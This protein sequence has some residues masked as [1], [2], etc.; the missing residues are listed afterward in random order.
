V[1]TDVYSLQRYEDLERPAQVP[2]EEQARLVREVLRNRDHNPS[3]V[4]DL[5]AGVEA[6]RLALPGIQE[7]IW[8]AWRE[9]QQRAAEEAEEREEPSTNSDPQTLR[10]F[11]HHGETNGHWSNPNRCHEPCPVYAAEAEALPSRR[12]LTSCRLALS[13]CAATA[14][15]IGGPHGRAQV[16]RMQKAARVA[17]EPEQQLATFVQAV[18]S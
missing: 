7:H 4:L 3:D 8:T 14:T 10:D 17:Y 12:T 11:W 16:P 9:E 13:G 2:E 15:I 1:W 18:L 5:A 6:A